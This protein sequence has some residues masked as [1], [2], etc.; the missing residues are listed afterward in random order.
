MSDAHGNGHDPK[1]QFISDEALN[2]L[3]ERMQGILAQ[4]LREALQNRKDEMIGKGKTVAELVSNIDDAAFRQ[5]LKD[6]MLWLKI[7]VLLAGLQNKPLEIITEAEYLE[8]KD[9]LARLSKLA[10]NPPT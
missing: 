9:Y 2:K 10:D 8:M 4:A 7:E 1:I 5:N 6:F 3:V